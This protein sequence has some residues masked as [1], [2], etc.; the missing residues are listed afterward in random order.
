[1]YFFN[2]IYF[3]ITINIFILIYKIVQ[4]EKNNLR[5]RN[6]HQNKLLLLSLPETIVQRI[7]SGKDDFNSLS[8]RV[9]DASVLFLGK[10]ELKI[11]YLFFK[12]IITNYILKN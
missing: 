7:Q 12:F 10:I 2:Y 3:W 4:L 11:Y 1:L 8:C 9:E 5:L 6:L